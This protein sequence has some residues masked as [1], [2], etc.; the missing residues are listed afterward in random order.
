MMKE[1]FLQE[2]A[3]IQDSLATG[4]VKVTS[5]KSVSLFD[6]EV[7]FEDGLG[8]ELFR[9]K[10]I[11][12][13]SGR[14]FV[15]EKLFNVGPANT[16]GGTNL[17]YPKNSTLNVKHKNTVPVSTTNDDNFGPRKEKIIC[18]F[19][20]GIGGAHPNIYGEVSA[21]DSVESEL[22][23]PIPFRVVEGVGNSSQDQG[24]KDLNQYYM[25]AEKDGN[26]HYYLKRFEDNGV[27]MYLK[28]GEEDYVPNPGED[29]RPNFPNDGVA[30]RQLPDS[31]E[32]YVELKLR[33]SPEDARDYFLLRDEARKAR[34]NEL[35]LYFGYQ[36]TYIDP[37]TGVEQ[38]R[39]YDE[40][41]CFSKLTF[42]NE[43]LDQLEKELLI[44]YRIYI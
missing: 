14:R 39:D 40:V 44:T 16:N 38:W 8:N 35:A 42:N 9:K 20:I 25:R 37:E 22:Y 1:M 7:I 21:P 13:V 27:Q 36:E 2:N 30:A 41:E 29:N 5:R 6:T 10:N 18:L 28:R 11:L 15:L 4:E 34:F 43:P 23:E 3:K 32:V 17:A 12:V 19:G 31:A 33:I 26:T 24:I